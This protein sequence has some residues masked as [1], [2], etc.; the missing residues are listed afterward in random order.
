MRRS[1][2][3]S[4]VAERSLVVLDR[5]HAREGRVA[6][7]AGCIRG[8]RGAPHPIPARIQPG[9][10]A[11]ATCGLTIFVVVD[12]FEQHAFGIPLILP[13]RLRAEGNGWAVA[14]RV[15]GDASLLIKAID[16]RLEQFAR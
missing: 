7:F 1:I 15:F 3:F 8:S 2:L 9:L 5:A 10:K 14:L 12:A 6:R 16:F 13:P 4:L 11:R